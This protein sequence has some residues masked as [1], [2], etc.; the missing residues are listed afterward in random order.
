MIEP[1]AHVALIREPRLLVAD[2]YLVLIACMIKTPVGLCLYITG[3][4]SAVGLHSNGFYTR[5]HQGEINH[6]KPTEHR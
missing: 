5:T 3:Q 4:I 2:K 1:A 6:A